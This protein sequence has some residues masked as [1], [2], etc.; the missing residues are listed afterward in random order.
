MVYSIQ[1]KLKTVCVKENIY[2]EFKCI[3][4]VRYDQNNIFQKLY[5]D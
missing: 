4:D 2:M 5:T 1:T 3:I